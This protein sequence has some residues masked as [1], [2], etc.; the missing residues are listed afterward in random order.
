M[1]NGLD[2]PQFWALSSCVPATSTRMAD[3]TNWSSGAGSE[4]YAQSD[5]I[6]GYINDTTAI[7]EIQFKMS[8]GNFDGVIQLFGIS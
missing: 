2:Q 3:L 1:A 6:A 8:S 4:T 5:F 7:D